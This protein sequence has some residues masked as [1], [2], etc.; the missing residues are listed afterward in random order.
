MSLYA[1]PASASE[2]ESADETARIVAEIAPDA[3]KAAEAVPGDGSVV[4]ATDAG[5]TE[6]PVDPSAPITITGEGGESVA[7]SLPA[8]TDLAEAAVASD[9]TVVFEDASGGSD[10]AV[11]SAVDG[12]L[13]VQT[14]IP[15]RTAE[16][17][18]TYAFGDGVTPVLQEDGSA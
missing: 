15:D 17:E 5:E 6:V 9:G 1:L 2:I 14:V 11:Q 12:T 8:E 13:R 16:H 10:V 7:V 3:D 18:F 4:F